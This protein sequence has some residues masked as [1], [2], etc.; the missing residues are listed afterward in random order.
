M[1]HRDARYDLIKPMFIGGK[2]KTFSDIFKFIPKTVVATDLGKKVDR[3]TDLMNKV[4]GFTVQE[5]FMMATF[6]ELEESE[7]LS[8][9]ENQYKMSKDKIKKLK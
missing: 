4:E 7:I 5:L 6:F 9:V 1:G 3:F 2:I 8:L